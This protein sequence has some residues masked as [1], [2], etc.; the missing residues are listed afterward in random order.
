MCEKYYREET[1]MPFF[2]DMFAY[3][4]QTGAWETE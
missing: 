4:L 2:K 1:K 3:V